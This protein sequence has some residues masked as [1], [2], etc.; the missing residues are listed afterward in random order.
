MAPQADWN[1]PYMSSTALFTSAEAC[2]ERAWKR[3]GGAGHA[4]RAA[5]MPTAVWL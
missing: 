3:V 2:W 4:V 1:G 5:A